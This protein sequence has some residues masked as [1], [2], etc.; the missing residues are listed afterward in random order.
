[1]QANGDTDE[2]RISSYL[3]SDG[4]TAVTRLAGIQRGLTQ[5]HVTH[6]IRFS[7]LERV[8]FCR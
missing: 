5:G 3:P 2:T 6:A 4:Q 7:G 8:F 1:M